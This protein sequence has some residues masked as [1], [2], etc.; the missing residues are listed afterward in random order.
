MLDVNSATDEI[1]EVY[2]ADHV[3]Q[4]CI[5]HKHSCKNGEQERIVLKHF[6]LKQ[7]C[8]TLCTL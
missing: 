8:N 6:Y 5:I 3:R 2:C 7:N 1:A 4:S